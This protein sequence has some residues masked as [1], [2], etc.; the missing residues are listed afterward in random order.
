VG[1]A[2]LKRR[3]TDIVRS[4][5]AARLHAAKRAA[6]AVAA[7]AVLTVPIAIGILS[8]APAFAQDDRDHVPVVRIAPE[9]PPEA[10]AAGLDGSVTLEFT[11]TTDGR[12]ADVVAVDSTSPLFEQAAV[13]ALRRWRYAPVMR[14]DRPFEL[15]GV[16]T[17]I[18]FELARD[19]EP[20]VRA[21]DG[22]DAALALR[23]GGQ[24]LLNL[25]L[26]AYTP[27]ERPLQ[28]AAG[29]VDVSQN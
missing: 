4:R 12:T 20:A 28:A 23:V 10:L 8:G 26:G 21:G 18:R 13:D 7:G 5:V 29:A 1:G 9:Y 14:D 2:D 16:Q 11:I 3:V 24:E 19:A 25:E 22:S 27:Q 15:R 17:I 6:F